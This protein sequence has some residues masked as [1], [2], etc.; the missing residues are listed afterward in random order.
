MFSIFFWLGLP[1]APACHVTGHYWVVSVDSPF[2][3]YSERLWEK[4]TFLNFLSLG[5][6]K[7]TL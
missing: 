4:Q 6:D 7:E 2:S 3:E 5:V 1:L